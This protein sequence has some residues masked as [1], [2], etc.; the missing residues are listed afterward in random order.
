MERIEYD[1]MR[2]AEDSYWWFVSRRRMA[3]R[4][5]RQ[6]RVTSGALLDL[7]CGTGAFLQELPAGFMGFGLDASDAALAHASSRGLAKLVLG[8]GE[9]LPFAGESFDA[10]VSLDTLEHIAGDANCAAEVHRV[11]R[12]GGMFV[13]NVPA[14]R[15]LWGPH[16]VA[17]HHHR[18]YVRRDVRRLLENAGFEVEHISY[19]VFFLF[20]VV[21]LIRL[22]DKLKTGEPQVKLPSVGPLNRFLV[23]LQDIECTLMVHTT[24]PWGSS[25]VAV[26][27]K[28]PPGA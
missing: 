14:Y 1:K 10:V 3:R 27:R 21:C 28:R 22:F 8:D 11:L 18:R 17:L 9:S 2:Q 26:A 15:W 13:M 6:H 24:L 5:L 23:W 12:P 20:P 25:V 19:S 16:D 7:G 4:L